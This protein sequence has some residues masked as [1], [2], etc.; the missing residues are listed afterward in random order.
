MIDFVDDDDGVDVS[1]FSGDE[2]A[3]NEGWFERR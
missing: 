1:S 3:V 2:V